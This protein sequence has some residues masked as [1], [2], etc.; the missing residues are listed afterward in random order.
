[1]SF[2]SLKIY[3]K[4]Y[5]SKGKRDKHEIGYS[6]CSGEIA[7]DAWEGQIEYHKNATVASGQP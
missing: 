5:E 4:A 1:M 7:I 3:F 2:L 6:Q